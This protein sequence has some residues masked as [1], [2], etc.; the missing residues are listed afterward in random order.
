MLK[1][2]REARDI[3]ARKELIE[4]QLTDAQ[5]ALNSA[6]E[7]H[8]TNASAQKML[9]ME[10]DAV[11]GKIAKYKT[12]QLTVKNNDEF[13]AL[14]NQVVMCRKEIEKHENREI[15]LM[16][17]AEVIKKELA[18][19]TLRMTE[20]QD[21]VA[22]EKEALDR[23]LANTLEDIERMKQKRAGMIADI[24]KETLRNYTRIMNNKKDYAIVPV[25]RDTCG[26]CH[27]KLTPQTVH[28]TKS[29]QKLVSC[30]YCGRMLYWDQY[31]G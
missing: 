4:G 30:S 9:E 2:M 24:D 31:A 28:D 29:R 10:I 3:P 11:K 1:Y 18:D 22:A 5:A 27:M 26:G 12:Q 8:K 23:R 25:E 16:E 20:A 19:C 14:E 21:R 17:K 7:R 6:E 15:D 13:R